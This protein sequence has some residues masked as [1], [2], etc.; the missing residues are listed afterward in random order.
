MTV[1]LTK[2]FAQDEFEC[3]CGCGSNNISA[4]L[5]EKLQKVRDILGK[6][7][8]VVSGVRCIS[9]NSK[10]GGSATSSHIDGEAVDVFCSDSGER[11][12]LVGV[13]RSQ[14]SRMG[15]AKEFIHVDV[16]KTKDS[17]VLWVY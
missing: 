16:S 1:Q 15:I 4:E 11:D 14:F 2:N 3:K 12:Y 13:L 7:I 6:P 9:H 10:I 5:V 17:P 8:R